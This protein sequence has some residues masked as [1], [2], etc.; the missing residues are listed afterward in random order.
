MKLIIFTNLILSSNSK[1]VQLDCSF[2]EELT[3][4]QLGNNKLLQYL[5]CY[6]CKLT[7]LDV[8]KCEKLESLEVRY[9]QLTNLI[10]PKNGKNLIN[11]HLSYN[12]LGF[13]L[14][15]LQHL[16]NLESLVLN[17]NPLT[18]SLKSLKDLQNL[19]LLSIENT[20]FV[21]N[22]E[23]LP[24]N[25]NAFYCNNELIVNLLRKFVLKLMLY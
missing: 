18:G 3:N 8:S 2:N 6:G 22:L 25:L 11:L 4:L 9:N 13:N 14:K 7:N 10:L 24:A 17:D 16:E 21:I 20:N 19:E 5:S 1:L 12:E 15:E 23:H